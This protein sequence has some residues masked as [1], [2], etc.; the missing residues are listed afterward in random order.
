MKPVPT[1][2]K[3]PGTIAPSM[4]VVEVRKQGLGYTVILT[5]VVQGKLWFFRESSPPGVE[6][7]EHVES[8]LVPGLDLSL[9]HI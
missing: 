2:K 7:N 4:V 3:I 5:K 6:A 9:I 8:A 1:L